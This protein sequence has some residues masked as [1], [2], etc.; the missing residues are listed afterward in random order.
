VSTSY[1]W[2]K[3]FHVLA[4]ITW[5]GG[6]VTLLAIAS[7]LSSQRDRQKLA[8]IAEVCDFVGARIVAPAASATLLAGII[9]VVVGHV[10][11]AFW[12]WWGVGATILVIAIGATVLRLGF[13]RLVELLNDPQPQAAAVAAVIRR[14]RSVGAFVILLLVT[15]VAIMV[16]K[17]TL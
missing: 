17:P 4:V 15:T 11:M 9:L 3:F 8:A 13:K 2:L 16:L 1:L 5:L 6:A 12:S 7:L 10:R 14:V